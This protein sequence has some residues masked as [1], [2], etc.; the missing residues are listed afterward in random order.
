MRG[1]E[2]SDGDAIRAARNVGQADAVAEF[3][4]VGVAA[5]LAADA[6][7]D[8]GAGLVALRSGNLDELA[9]AG[10]VNRGEQILFHD[11][12]FGVSAEERTGVVAL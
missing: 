6:E 1:G 3:H 11:F 4:G 12:V 9:D 8:A 2:A 5:V 10:L 7:L